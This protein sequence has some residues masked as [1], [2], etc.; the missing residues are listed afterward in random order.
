VARHRPG[1]GDVPARD[2][3]RRSSRP[4]P[5]AH[6]RHLRRASGAGSAPAVRDE[7]RDDLVW[8]DA[9]A[10]GR[11][12]R[13]ARRERDPM[14]RTRGRPSRRGLGGRIRRGHGGPRLG[15][16][17]RRRRLP[18]SRRAMGELARGVPRAAVPRP[19]DR[20]R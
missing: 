13:R 17:L 6:L 1:G 7:R 12:P 14:L 2:A 8:A 10:L 19:V 4:G 20:A 9:C 5:R 15:R 3:P 18:L 11:V 16:P